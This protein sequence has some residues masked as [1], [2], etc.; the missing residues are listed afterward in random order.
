MRVILLSRDLMLSSQLAG[1]VS[2]FKTELATKASVA[3]VVEELDPS[4]ATLLFVDLSLPGL[5]IQDLRNQLPPSCEVPP[6]II[7]FGP[8]VHEEKLAAAREAGCDMVLSRGQ[9][10]RG[11]DQILTQNLT[12]N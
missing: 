9:F 10:I 7:A 12:A 1:H 3:E 4:S 2:R 11:M 8:H 5:N 6:R